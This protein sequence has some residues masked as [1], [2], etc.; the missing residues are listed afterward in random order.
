[1]VRPETGFDEIEISASEWTHVH[2]V[3]LLWAMRGTQA[4]MLWTPLPQV[5]MWMLN[6]LSPAAA[7]FWDAGNGYAAFVAG[8]GRHAQAWSM[9][10][11]AARKALAVMREIGVDA[12]S[13]TA[14]VVFGGMTRSFGERFM[15]EELDPDFLLLA[16]RHASI[17]VPDGSRSAVSR[18]FHRQASAFGARAF[19]T[20]DESH[21]AAGAMVDA[22]G[23]AMFSLGIDAL[24]RA[25]RDEVLARFASGSW[26]AGK[27]FGL[28]HGCRGVNV[29]LYA[30]ICESDR[31]ASAN[32]LRFRARAVMEHGSLP[33][34]EATR[35]G[36]E[37]PG[38][39]SPALADL[40][41]ELR[42]DFD[43]C[44]GLHPALQTD[45][46]AQDGGP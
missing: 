22:E 11:G 32:L 39:N 1:M 19:R 12:R 9:R 15:P 37:S 2:S 27:E 14:Q 29:T 26:R 44:L 13:F 8:Q 7:V 34:M 10:E 42:A 20:V 4:H 3:R 31:E 28:M 40:Q 25:Q 36:L 33:A 17:A 18:Y 24:S 21:D 41:E 6:L 35:A 38:W 43:A 45:P 46:F 23:E 30:R 16:Q 5:G